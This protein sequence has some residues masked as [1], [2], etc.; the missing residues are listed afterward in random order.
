[1]PIT[2]TLPTQASIVEVGPRDGLQN[3]PGRINLDDKVDLVNALAQAGVQRIEAGAFVNPTWVPQMADSFDVFTHITRTPGVSYSAL[4]P[5]IK[6]FDRALAAGADEVAI[7][8]AASEAFSQKNLNCDINTSLERFAEVVAAAQ[9][10]NIP[11][12]GYISC[13]LGCPYSGRV[14]LQTCLDIAR[15][16]LAMGCYEISLGD[17]IGVGTAAD[18]QRLLA[19]L[20]NDIPVDQ[21]A[22]HMHDT[23]GQALS[24][25]LAAL[26]MGVHVIDSSVAGLGGCPYA[27]G[28]TG[29]VATE[30]VIYLLDGLGINHG[31]NLPQ[32][33]AAGQ[34]ICDRLGKR[35]NSKVSQ[36]HSAR[37]QTLHN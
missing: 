33:M 18:T 14:E 1:M 29:N 35:N 34:R 6:G 21:L 17:T 37:S 26:Q 19:C 7:F 9:A 4:T 24:N 2:A 5:N 23:Y 22:V 3:E 15:E 31:I 8:A 20:L 27:Q 36:A 16:L 13:V 25:I 30:D 32:L 12:R 10:N 11:V 28:A